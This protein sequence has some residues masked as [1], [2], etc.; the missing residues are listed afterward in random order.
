M[1]SSEDWL[2]LLEQKL[3]RLIVADLDFKYE[4]GYKTWLKLNAPKD[5]FGF[6]IDFHTLMEY[7]HQK[8]T[9][10]DS[11]V[12]LGKLYKI[13]N[14]NTVEAIVMTSFEVLAPCFLT[15]SR[16]HTV[17]DAEVPYFTYI[18]SYAK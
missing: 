6:M 15:A 3:A 14:K 7:I 18:I 8:I 16:T 2:I 17:I 4:V 10:V 1:I 12:S 9:G 13:R 5:H 11:L